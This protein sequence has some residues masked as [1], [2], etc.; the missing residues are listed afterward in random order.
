MKKDRDALDLQ[1]RPASDAAYAMRGRQ[2]RAALVAF[3]F[4]L[5]TLQ[6]L[7]INLMPLLFGTVAR[8]FEDVNLRQQGQL[9]TFFLAGGIV[10]LFVSGYVTETIRAKRSGT[11]AVILIGVGSLL[12]G[13]A[14]TYAH[15]LLA[16][17]VMGLGA[18]WVL[19]AYSAVITAHFA[20]MRQRMFMWA[21]AAFAG[22]ATLGSSLFGYLLEMVPNWQVIFLVFAGVV[23]VGYGAFSLLAGRRLRILGQPALS[24]DPASPSESD[25]IATR[26]GNALKFL[27]S[28]LLNRGVFW[29]L[30]LLVVLDMFA[31]GNIVAWTARFFQITYH[32]GDDQVGFMLSASAA[33]VFVGRL[34][35]GA[36]VSGRFTDRTVLGTCYAAGILMYVLILLIPSYRAGVVLVFLNGAFIAAQAPT[37]YAIASARFGDRA[38]T[39]IPLM[40][41]IGVLGGFMGP[42]AVGALADR[43][44]LHAVLWL[45]PVVGFTL[46][47]IV[48][49]WHAV[50]RREAHDA[51][52]AA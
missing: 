31:A 6:G 47:L 43:H 52:V 28:G 38:A 49:A 46:V 40:D 7:T 14:K 44:G 24:E 5:V 18:M 17:S 1:D 16:A 4:T 10:A 27:A 11:L 51:S 30:G 8:T 50:D 48:F 2:G 41:A 9:Q 29:L 34:L 25:G 33:G 19:S 15:V 35:M 21:T 39:A 45:I 32:V 3:I 42:A 12:L 37:M 20:D 23:W 13:L 36:F 26:L 22:S